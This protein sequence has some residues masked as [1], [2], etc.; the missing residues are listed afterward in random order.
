MSKL[1]KLAIY[2]TPTDYERLESQALLLGRDVDEIGDVA[3]DFI[4]DGIALREREREEEAARAAFVA[5]EDDD[6]PF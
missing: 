5:R 3:Y 6:I 2:L 1:V 4:L